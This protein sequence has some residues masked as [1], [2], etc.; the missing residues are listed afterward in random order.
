M[1]HRIGEKHSLI[2]KLLENKGDI[3]SFLKNTI[4]KILSS[5]FRK[6]QRLWPPTPVSFEAIRLKPI[7]SQFGFDRGMPLDRYYIEK[8]L[9]KYSKYITGR[10]LEVGNSDYSKKFGQ[11]VTAFHVLHVC[12]NGEGYIVGDLSKLETLPE[13]I[14][15]CFICTQTFN[16]ILDVEKA[17]Q[18]AAK[19][20][21]PGGA[22]LATVSGI[23]QISRYD[24]DRW[25]DYWRFTPLSAEKL[26][27]RYFSDVQVFSYGN[28]FI[29]KACL[30][31]LAVE[32]LANKESLET[33]DPD[34]PVSIAIFAKKAIESPQN[35]KNTLTSEAR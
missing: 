21:V 29:A 15:D 10:V 19:L 22:L 20:L 7:S 16:F 23:S 24:M 28:V 11:N 14:A 31:G 5:I 18:G 3:M 26:F 6:L 9:K 33:D 27:G 25:G 2:L 30:D 13:S 12:D 35:Q 1:L 32:D 17:I 34:Y 8:F 4:K